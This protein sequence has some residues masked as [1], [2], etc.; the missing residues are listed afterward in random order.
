M[1]KALI[2]DDNKKH[3][4]DLENFDDDLLQ[5]NEEDR[6]FSEMERHDNEAIEQ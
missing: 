2:H 6:I 1:L 4:K 3:D 5:N